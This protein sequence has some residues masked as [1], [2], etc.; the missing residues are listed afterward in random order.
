MKSLGY[1]LDKQEVNN[2][3]HKALNT[4]KTLPVYRRHIKEINAIIERMQL[5]PYKSS[6]VS[7]QMRLF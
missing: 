7:K 1:T 3:A 5:T 2:Y 4:S 6:K